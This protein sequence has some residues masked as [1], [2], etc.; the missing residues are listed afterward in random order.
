[1]D[2]VKRIAK[3]TAAL[4]IANVVSAILG[5]FYGIYIARYLGAE[6]YGIIAFSIAFINLFAI[7]TDIGL[8]QL[9]MR[10]IARDK[11]LTAKY[12]GNIAVL[13][14]FLVF[15]AYGIIIVVIHLLG[16]PES[17]IQ[18]VYVIG[19]TMVCGS[20][21]NL[22]NSIFQAHEKMEY[23]SIESILS[24]SLMLAGGLF[25]I[26]MGL[27][28]IGFA[29]VYSVSSFAV[30]AYVVLVA[31]KLGLPLN[32][33]ADLSFIKTAAKRAIPFGVGTFFMVY[34][35]W[36]ARVMLS[37]LMDYRN[38]GYYT[39]AYNFMGLFTFI[40]NAFVTSLFPVMSMSFNTSEESL[41]RILHNGIRYMYMLALPMAVGVTLLGGNI[42]GL[43]YGPGF[44]PAVGPLSILIWAEFLVFMDV[45]LGQMLLSINRE[46]WSM[47]SAGIGSAL[48]ILLNIIL[49]PRVGMVGAALATF[50]TEFFFFLFSLYLLYRCGYRIDVKNVVPKPLFATAVMSAFILEF[51]YLPLFLL[52][53]LS[54]ILYF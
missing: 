34:Y 19:L 24:G 42:I 14:A 29:A 11:S 31:I 5:F 9:M 43:I 8:L 52:I 7:F 50:S 48:N 10:D 27:P 36:I 53:A 51:T 41:R 47:A 40:P 6:K 32:I 45:L 54:A 18:I 25:A 15:L 2:V 46:R 17:T 39:A 23:V 49:I 37:Y 28:L 33:E 12:L 38:V 22:F 26:Y 1:M 13:K 4:L 30:L 21:I 35:V 3:N 16:Y 44:L 20:F